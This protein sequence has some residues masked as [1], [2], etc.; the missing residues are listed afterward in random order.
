M[1]LQPV[2][3]V[4]VTMFDGQTLTFDDVTT[5]EPINTCHPGALLDPVP[6]E[7]RIRLVTLE[8]GDIEMDGRLIRSVTV[9]GDDTTEW[10]KRTHTGLRRVASMTTAAAG[11]REP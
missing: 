7:S 10:I 1:P 8:R 6:F 3:R 9:E 2:A 11:V 4:T 5:V